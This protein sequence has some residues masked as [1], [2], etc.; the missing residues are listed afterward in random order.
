MQRSYEPIKLFQSTLQFLPVFH[1]ESKVS[2]SVSVTFWWVN[3]GRKMTLGNRVQKSVYLWK[4]T[5]KILKDF[6][7]SSWLIEVQLIFSSRVGWF[8]F[9]WGQFSELLQLM[10]WLQSDHRAADVTW[11]RFQLR[12]WFRILSVALEKE[13]KVPDSASWLTCY[14]WLSL[15]C[16]PLFLR[17]L[18]SLIRLAL[19]L[20]LFCGQRQVAAPEKGPQGPALLHWLLK[21]PPAVGHPSPPGG[22][23]LLIGWWSAPW[24]DPS[25]PGH[26]CFI[27]ASRPT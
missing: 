16:L 26:R 17:S 25:H 10:S 23:H 5:L 3:T 15:D 19:W 22:P 21:L 11:W 7:A 6:E 20:K 12:I 18:T 4:S 8:P 14:C 27:R 2:T 24:G 13:L 9:L 1:L